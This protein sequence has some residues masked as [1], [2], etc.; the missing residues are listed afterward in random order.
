ML[1]FLI[2]QLVATGA[3]PVGKM[4]SAVH[5]RATDFGLLILSRAVLREGL[6]N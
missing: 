3:A 6:Y 2:V 4:D 5:L 1:R